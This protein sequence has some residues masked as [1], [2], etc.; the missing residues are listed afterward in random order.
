MKTSLINRFRILSPFFGNYPSWLKLLKRREFGLELKRRGRARVQ[1]EMAE[2]ITL[3][4]PF[5]SKLKFWSF[6]VVVVQG[7]Q[8]NVQKS[9]LH[10]LSCCFAHWTYCFLTFPL[11]SPWWFRI[12]DFKL[13]RFWQTCVNRKLTFCIC[14]QWLCHNFRQT[15][16]TRINS[17]NNAN[18][19]ALKHNTEEKVSLSVASLNNAFA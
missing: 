16:F 7:R 1:K 18:L 11:L 19:V 13:R 4:F 8:R 12:K 15:V 10:V 2:F 5:P 9:V 14:L 6:H 3:L 17:L